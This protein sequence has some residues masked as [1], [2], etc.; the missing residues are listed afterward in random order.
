MFL[1]ARFPSHLEI[2]WAQ[3]ATLSPS[4]LWGNGWGEGNLQQ[5]SPSAVDTGA[6][7][8]ALPVHSEVVQI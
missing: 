4:L 3:P 1:L 5:G 2:G 6:L 8:D 7:G